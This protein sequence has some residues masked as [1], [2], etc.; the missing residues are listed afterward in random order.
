M[1]DPHLTP[2]PGTDWHVWRSAL[3]RSAGFPADGMARFAAP[4]LA[5]VADRF[6]DGEATARE[7][8]EAFDAALGALGAGVYQTAADP[9]FRSALT[10]QNPGALSSVAGVLRDGPDAPRNERRRRREEIVA[11]YWQRYCLKN[12]TIGFFGPM[13]WTTVG[14]EGPEGTDGPIVAGAPGPGLV[15]LRRAFFEWWALDALGDTIAADPRVR[16]WLPVRLEPHV[17][18]RAR[19]LL[20]PNEPPRRVSPATA[21]LLTAARRRRR[22]ADLAVEL[23]SDPGGGLRREAD[24]YAELAELA[25]SGVLR[26]GF[27]LPMD[28]T[29]ADTLRAQL[30]E[31]DD[32]PARDAALRELDALCALRDAAAAA[33]DPDELAVAMTALERRFEEVTGQAPRRRP[34]QTYAGRTLC[35]LEAVRDLDISFGDDVLDRL[36]A[37]EPLLRSARWLTAAVA[38]AYVAALAE[39]YE[40]LADDAGTREIPFTDLWF[41]AQGMVLGTA[42]G[43]RSPAAI[44]T[45]DFVRRWGEVLGLADVPPGTRELHFTTAELNERVTKVFPADAPGWALA[46]IHSPDLHLCAPDRAALERGEYT[47]VLGELHIGV[48]A[49]DSHFFTLGHPD[50]QALHAGMV[51]DLPDGR[52]RLLVPPDWPRYCARNAEWM[53]G[54]RDALVGFAPAPGAD[55]E[56]H[57]P[58]TALTVVPGPSGLRLRADDGREWPLV[59]MFAYLFDHQT[60]DTWKLA[61]T[62]EHT[63][64]VCVDGLVLVRE[65]WRATVAATGLAD[66]TGERDRYLAVRDWRRRVGLPDRVFVRIDTE[67]KPFFVDL[68]SPLYTRLLC[69]MLRGARAKGG[70]DVGITVTELLPG[71]EHAWLVDAAGRRYASE[72]RLQIR[73]PAPAGG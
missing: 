6:L 52:V 35:H 53:H 43:T 49:F 64:R 68:T 51:A 47:V 55:T 3:L 12:D 14:A 39:L 29:A 46:R 30:G 15:R 17:T 28:L 13:C 2:L 5:R 33:V 31:V 56:R 8:S 16:P 23:V 67:L 72:L 36:A 62:A 11:K 26:V 38:D 37:L 65:T 70:P 45:A 73:D 57:V 7:L 1:A 18:L 4:E 63:P 27:D 54:P 21:A 25:K 58:I 44:V 9:A 60:F 71:P 22:A 41:V 61:G 32:A 40:D 69:T 34:G 20:V 50:P 66:V 48:P 42:P 19:E 10:W 24:V 59:E